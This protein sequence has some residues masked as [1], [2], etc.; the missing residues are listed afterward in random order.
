VLGATRLQHVRMSSLPQNLLRHPSCRS[1]LAD[2]GPGTKFQRV[3]TDPNPP[4]DPDA[5][6][7]VIFCSGKIYYE[8][9]AAR[10][11]S[12]RGGQVAIV[13][14]EQLSPFP[15]DRVSAEAAKYPNAEVAWVQEE[16][17]N[18]GPYPYVEDRI[19]TANRELCNVRRR[20]RYFGRKPSAAPATGLAKAHIFEQ[21]ELIDGAI[22]APVDDEYLPRPVV[23]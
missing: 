1:T 5:V 22:N 9:D 17:K 19:R 3:L 2:M 15:H 4:E 18:S 6:E 23:A 7:R 11:E 20:P 16:P 13:R 21:N 8:L 14:V 10:T 12:G